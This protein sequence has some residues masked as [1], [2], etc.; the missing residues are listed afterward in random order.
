MRRGSR[1]PRR[2]GLSSLPRW[3]KPVHRPDPNLIGLPLT[4][5]DHR[6]TNA[7]AAR[8][9]KRVVELDG[10]ARSRCETQIK[11]AATAE[12]AA[13]GI[14]LHDLAGLALGQLGEPSTPFRT[15]AMRRGGHNL[16]ISRHRARKPMLL[17][18]VADN[19]PLRVVLNDPNGFPGTQLS[20]EDLLKN[21]IG[22]VL[23]VNDPRCLVAG[24][25]DKRDGVKRRKRAVR[26]WDRVA[27]RIVLRVP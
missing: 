20:G 6:S 14:E 11:K 5:S 22:L 15:P 19:Q 25:F 4:E 13:I 18:A 12:P 26:R 23:D 17:F 16:N 3:S 27:V 10:D 7:V 2:A 1:A 21:H 24:P 8:V 9:S